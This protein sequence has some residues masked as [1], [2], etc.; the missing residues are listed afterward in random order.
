MIDK[1]ISK[2]SLQT[3]IKRISLTFDDGP[4]RLYTPKIL[5]ILRDFNIKAT[6]F[7]VGKNA[8]N[9]PDIITRINKEG[10]D[11]GNHTFRHPVSPLLLRRK[12]FIRE[13]ILKT[14]RILNKILGKIPLFFRPPLA[15]WD[16]SSKDLI[17]Q[18]RKFGHVSV[19]WSCSSVD[20]IG[21]RKIIANKILK[22]PKKDG[23]IIL[24]HDGAEKTFIKKRSATVEML[25]A[26]IKDLQEK[27][28]QMLSL[29]KLLSNFH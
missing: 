1:V 11:I 10:H 21:S 7:V 26:I 27:S 23:D 16:A 17:S 2:E 15:R 4:D 25:P 8:Q 6:F 5:D 14:N 19:G 12:N 9:N 13:E 29:T 18:A 24:L 28:F 22:N 20:W 3:G